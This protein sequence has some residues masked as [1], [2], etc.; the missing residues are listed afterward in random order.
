MSGFTTHYVGIIIQFLESLVK[1]E[2]PTTNLVLLVAFSNWKLWKIKKI[3]PGTLLTKLF[4]VG[5]NESINI[6]LIESG[7]NFR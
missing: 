6:Q 1:I 7:S 3:I 2:E 4:E 5:E